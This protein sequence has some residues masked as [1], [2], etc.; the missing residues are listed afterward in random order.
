MKCPVIV[1]PEQLTFG[2]NGDPA[3]FKDPTRTVHI[4]PQMPLSAAL[5]TYWTRDEHF[6][7]YAIINANGQPEP[8]APRLNKKGV[9]KGGLS[10]FGGT[11]LFSCVVADVEPYNFAAGEADKVTQN[12]PVKLAAWRIEQRARVLALPWAATAA[13]YNTLHGYRLVWTLPTPY[14]D[15][16]AY[17]RFTEDFRRELN[18]FGIPA[19]PHTPDW[20]RL[21]RLPRVPRY[22]SIVHEADLAAL[23]PYNHTPPPA[24]KP[25]GE[26]K[27]FK[28]I[29]Q[30]G[31]SLVIPTRVK[32]GSRNRSMVRIA[33]SLRHKG[34]SG[35]G[36]LA[37]MR[38]ENERINDP[39]LDDAELQS[40]VS[41][42]MEQEGGDIGET[43]AAEAAHAPPPPPP[44][45]G[46]LP[47]P[48]PPPASPE[49]GQ[50]VTIYRG[51]TP[52]ILAPSV[53]PGTELGPRLLHGSEVEI[54]NVVLADMEQGG[55]EF[56]A[57]RGEMWRYDT[58]SGVWGKLPRSWIEAWIRRMD[59][60]PMPT[61]STPGGASEIKRLRVTQKMVRDIATMC[62][63]IR[64]KNGFFNN[65]P[66]GV[67]FSNGFL[68]LDADGFRPHAPENRARH[69]L[70]FEFNP[71]ATAPRWERAL[72]EWLSPT[73]SDWQRLANLL[74]EFVGAA[75]FGIATRYEVAIILFGDRA[76]NG[77][78]QFI[79][80]V[81]AL[82]PGESLAGV[83]PQLMDDMP[84]RAKLESARLNVVSEMPDSE[85]LKSAGFKQFVSG[86]LI[87]ARAIYR[88]G[89]AYRPNAAHLMAANR[90]PVVRDTTRGFWRR[91]RVV[92]FH[93]TF[94][95]G[96]AGFTPNLA[97]E[98]IANELPGVATWAIAGAL[99][100]IERKGYENPQA[101]QEALQNWQLAADQIAAFLHECCNTVV[102][103]TTEYTKAMDLYTA[104][105]SW[106]LRNKGQAVSTRTFGVRLREIGL[107]P[108][109]RSAGA[110]YP[111]TIR[112][113]AVA[114][115]SIFG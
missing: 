83:P 24:G 69:V 110:Y 10:L 14:V 82:F 56:V 25:S 94:R 9:D 70:P 90:L 23:G 85:V 96:D 53:N 46:V 28:G 80:V 36:M 100:L 92:P 12:D 35:E 44:P 7:T 89:F 74:A 99:R 37:L 86:E 47:P 3:E 57:D 60:E 58:A 30:A 107:P 11:L 1:V 101:C 73:G 105:T 111:I 55:T 62:L 2:W 66:R 45:S 8:S 77:K 32:E 113:D 103:A 38:V 67:V 50:P 102:T 88:D 109:Q 63:S 104:Y 64:D 71:G 43:M 27:L 29:G 20:T 33:G 40:I 84:A 68:S 42:V 13:K 54:A 34:Y 65:A 22:A 79:K 4:H 98:I 6:T 87:E 61:K 39:P 76:A 41:W 78:S 21:F 91:W 81:S 18:T 95:A 49:M 17:E 31:K 97:G 19:D 16:L 26:G 115:P 15:P 72:Y 106:V 48:L 114:R 112:K 93:A 108:V 59:M 51:S 75:L 52:T 5:E